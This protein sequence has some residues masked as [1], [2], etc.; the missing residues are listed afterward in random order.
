[1]NSGKICYQGN[2]QINV[3]WTHIKKEIYTNVS[4]RMTPPLPILMEI[5]EGGKEADSN[6]K[7]PITV[8]QLF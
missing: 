5:K 4:D 2:N 6:L 3:V 8:L 7:G 1:M